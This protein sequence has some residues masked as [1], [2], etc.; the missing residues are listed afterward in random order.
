M[1]RPGAAGNGYSKITYADQPTGGVGAVLESTSGS[2]SVWNGGWNSTTFTVDRHKPYLYTCYVR[3]TSSAAA[4]TFYFGLYNAY[5]QGTS[6]TV[7][8][9][10]YMVITSTSTLVQHVWHLVYCMVYPREY[11]GTGVNPQNPG[12]MRGLWRIDNMDRRAGQ[13]GWRHYQDS[14]QMRS[15]LYLSLIHI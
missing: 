2:S 1:S 3:R 14:Q 6:T 8:T 10:P 7:N 9:N 13:T 12:D 11:N 4:G 5:P 15:Y